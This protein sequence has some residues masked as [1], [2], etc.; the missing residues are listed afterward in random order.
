MA[1]VATL[2]LLCV[3]VL[4]NR[5]HSSYRYQVLRAISMSITNSDELDKIDIY[6]N[7]AVVYTQVD[8]AAIYKNKTEKYFKYIYVC[9]EIV[10]S[11]KGHAKDTPFYRLLDSVH[12]SYFDK[13][14]DYG[15]SIRPWSRSSIEATWLPGRPGGF[16]LYK[17]D[18]KGNVEVENGA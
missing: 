10:G 9:G 8:V 4:L 1:L 17:L 15:L 18:E 3:S 11:D 13:R 6:V 12:S 2:F 5:K 7:D 14:P 16:T